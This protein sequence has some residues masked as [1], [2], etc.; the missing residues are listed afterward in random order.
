MGNFSTMSRSRINKMIGF[1]QT[2][3]QNHS[4]SFA[5]MKYLNQLYFGLKFAHDAKYRP[6]YAN[7]GVKTQ[8]NIYQKKIM[9]CVLIL[10]TREQFKVAKW[11]FYQD[12]SLIDM[13]KRAWKCCKKNLPTFIPIMGLILSRYYPVTF[14]A[15]SVLNSRIFS[16]PTVV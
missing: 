9:E 10:W 11:T 1:L 7:D 14:F 3:M 6:F 12:F 4:S 2:I 16:S 13:E 5:E 15:C 8:Q